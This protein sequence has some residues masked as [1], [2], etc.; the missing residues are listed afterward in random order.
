MGCR[1]SSRL[2]KL[3]D[4]LV[5]VSFFLSALVRNNS[6]QLR[7]VIADQYEGRLVWKSIEPTGMVWY[8]SLAV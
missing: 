5:A 8:G 2:V 3:R 4:V 6:V 1:L 7:D